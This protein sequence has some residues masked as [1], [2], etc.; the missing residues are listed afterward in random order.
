[1]N[2]NV[3]MQ[4]KGRFL[5]DSRITGLGVVNYVAVFN[6]TAQV[7]IRYVAASSVIEQ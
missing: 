2:F 1:M 3:N 5:A 7:A 6:V 4:V